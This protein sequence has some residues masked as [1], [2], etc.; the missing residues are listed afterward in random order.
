MRLTNG[1]VAVEFDE[2]T[3]SLVQIE[4]LRAGIKHLSDPAGGRLLRVVVPDEAEWIGRYCDSHES[5]PPEMRLDGARAIIRFPDLKVAAGGSTFKGG[6]DSG[7]EATVTVSLPPGADEARFTLA[8]RNGG[9]HVIQEVW[10]PRVGGWCGY[11]ARGTDRFLAGLNARASDPFTF[12]NLSG[13]G[14]TLAKVHRRTF[15]NFP[16]MVAPMLDV[17]GSGR[18]L[19]Y[20]HYPAAPRVGGIVLE[21]LNVEGGDV[22]PA[23]SWVHVPFIQPGASW[24]SDP[25]GI[26]PHTSDWHATAD[27]MRAWLETWWQPPAAPQRLRSAIGYFNMQFRDFEGLELHPLS[28][29]PKA[30]HYCLDHGIRDF[31]LWDMIANVYLRAGTG[32]FWEDRPERVAELSRVL[33]EIRAMGVQVSTLI[34]L[35]LITEKNRLWE[36]SAPD[37]TIRSLYGA[38]ARESWP[39]RSNT[40]NFFSPW[41]EESGWRLCQGNPAFQAW[42]LD[43]VDRTLDLGFSSLF[44]DQPFSRDLCFSA[45]HGHAVPAHV[46]EGT[47]AWIRRAVPKVT[48]RDPEGYVIGENADIWNSDAIQLW[49]NWAWAGFDSEVFRYTM[50]DSLQSWIIDALEPPHRTQVGKAFAQGFLLSMDVCGLERPLSDVPEFAARIR[51][52]ADLRSRTA[53]FTVEGRFCDRQGLQVDSDAETAAGLYR[54]GERLGVVVSDVSDKRS[55]LKLRLD[56]AALGQS[57]PS[58]VRLYRQHGRVEVLKSQTAGGELQVETTLGPLEA[59]VVE[60]I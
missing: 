51:Q 41:L 45:S 54:A 25:V 14:Y 52:L 29:A 39:C 59:A 31:C 49:W 6:E 19:S 27:R 3:G 20:I 44:I 9:P 35:R 2:K 1:L 8:V 30:A 15:M 43:L 38:S 50:P 48:A 7:I 55:T 34:N 16:G 26:A 11:G 32:G 47:S 40:G 33:K 22:R 58:Q 12:R 18:G 17:S 13:S 53:A 57:C 46:H 24:T 10:F 21:D 5:G 4:D 56:A 28:E 23:W 60:V 37:R 42:A 36:T